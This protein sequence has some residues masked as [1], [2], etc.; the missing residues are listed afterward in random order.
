[1]R[2]STVDRAVLL[3]YCSC[4]L[5]TPS[6]QAAASLC[7]FFARAF[8]KFRCALGILGAT[9]GTVVAGANPGMIAKSQR[10]ADSTK[11]RRHNEPLWECFRASSREALDGDGPATSHKAATASP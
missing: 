4:R 10:L 3:P 8:R 6:R 9:S 1:M 2:T 5:A 7:T 11:M